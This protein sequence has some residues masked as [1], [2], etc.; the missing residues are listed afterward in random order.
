VFISVYGNINHSVIAASLNNIGS[1]YKSKNDYDEALKYFN[2]SL[3]MNRAIHD[4][5]NHSDIA[6]PL[7]N[8][9][10]VYKS[11][12]DYDEALKY[13]NES[14]EICYNNKSST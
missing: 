2:E 6:A 7:N 5:I 3:K 14:K 4:N 12:N 10:S 13:Y 9:G 8:I 1:V 11:K